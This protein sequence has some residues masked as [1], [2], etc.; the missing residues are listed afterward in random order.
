MKVRA[1]LL[2]RAAIAIDINA[3]FFLPEL[4]AL[5]KD[6]YQFVA[7]P[8]T[9]SEILSEDGSLRFRHGKVLTTDGKTIVIND[10]MVGRRAVVVDV[11]TPTIHD[12]TAEANYV[13]TE[14]IEWWNNSPYAAVSGL[15]PLEPRY[16]VSRLEVSLDNPLDRAFSGLERVSTLLNSTIAKYAKWNFTPP[17]VSSFRVESVSLVIDPTRVS[18]PCDF[19]LERRAGLPYDEGVYFAQAPLGTDDHI[20]VLAELEKALAAA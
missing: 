18:L 5:F 8:T 4:I 3:N 12:S 11:A 19:S 7:T 16:Y 20:I 10:M 14:L 6:K 13:L 17:P 2:A 9:P 1:V 15:L